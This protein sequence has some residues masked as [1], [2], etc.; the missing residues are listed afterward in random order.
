MRW[1]IQVRLLKNPMITLYAAAF[2]MYVYFVSLGTETYE[3]VQE[4]ADD[5]VALNL[6]GTLP[7]G[8]E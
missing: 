7:E 4:D 1:A 5:S 3:E 2:L 8:W 6:D